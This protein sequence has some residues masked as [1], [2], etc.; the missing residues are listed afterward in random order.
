MKTKKR[1]RAWFERKVS[2]LGKAIKQL[3]DERQLELFAELEQSASKEE[4]QG[5]ERK[6]RN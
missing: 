6:N 3:P 5:D 2:E 1:D 4:R